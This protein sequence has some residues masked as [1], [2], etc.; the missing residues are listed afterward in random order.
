MEETTTPKK[1]RVKT[2]IRIN[3]KYARNPIRLLRLIV[4]QNPGRF[5]EVPTGDKGDVIWLAPPFRDPDLD[6]IGSRLINFLPGFQDVSQKKELSK[7]LAIMT[8]FFPEQYTFYP[9]TWLFPE[10]AE[11]VCEAMAR[12]RTGCFI[13]K[14]TLASQGDGISIVKTERDLMA[15]SR[16]SDVVVQEYIDPP[17]LLYK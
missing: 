14:P 16:L 9:K 12:R 13:L 1:K 11:E 6:Y 15:V 4:E 3:T 10:Q 5:S 2:L 8:E 7:N 17:L